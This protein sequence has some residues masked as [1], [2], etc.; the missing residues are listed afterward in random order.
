MSVTPFENQKKTIIWD[1]HWQSKFPGKLLLGV[2]VA[3]VGVKQHTFRTTVM[4]CVGGCDP[5]GNSGGAPLQNQENHHWH[6]TWGTKFPRKVI[7][8]RVWVATIGVE[9]HT[10]RTTV[11]GLN[12]RVTIGKPKKPSLASCM[13]NQIF[14][15][16][17][18]GAGLGG[19][20][21]G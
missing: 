18:H 8:G 11:P 13:G 14:E 17:N 21:W 12:G 5:I 19:N 10:F 7:I 4:G 20:D 1:T 16:S 3:T 15:K 2:G 9:Q 6:H